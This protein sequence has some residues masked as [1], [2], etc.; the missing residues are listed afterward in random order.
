MQSELYHTIALTQVKGVGPEGARTLISACG[1]AAEVFQASEKELLALPG[2]GPKTVEYIKSFE[3]YDRVE[4]ELEF[5]KTH[6]IQALTFADKGYP[7]RLKELSNAPAVVFYKGTEVLNHSRVIGI[8]GTRRVSEYGKALVQQLVQDLAPYNVVTV[9][10][11]AY[12]VDILC[13]RK[14][15]EN[16]LPT[17]SVM[18]HGLD[19]VYPSAHTATA[20][21]MTRSGGIMT[22]HVSGTSMRKE[23][24]PRRNRLVAGLI[25]ALVVVESPA[26]GG[27]LITAEIAH[28]YHREV[29]AFPGRI[30]DDRSA[31]CN[32]LI[33]TQKAQL[34]ESAADLAW[35]LGWPSPDTQSSQNSKAAQLRGIEKRIYVYL[36]EKPEQRSKLDLMCEELDIPQGELSL[37]LLNMEF[38]GFVRCMPGNSF[39]AE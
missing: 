38:N 3:A 31:G 25:D 17:V 21:Q 10:G 28:S 26:K 39:K 32:N 24:F 4:K 13:H 33:K 7:A 8:V 20:R 19:M 37:L 12:G 2:L 1:S 30:N 6:N 29:L 9:S 36:R 23:Y 14:S 15:L 35:F 18:A 34:I 11:M 16:Q 22:E 5:I 27:S